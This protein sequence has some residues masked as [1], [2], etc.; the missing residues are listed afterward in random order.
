MRVDEVARDIKTRTCRW[1]GGSNL[2]SASTTMKMT[3]SKG[4]GPRLPPS[5][6]EA[7][8]GMNVL[9]GKNPVAKTRIATGTRKFATISSVVDSLCHI[10]AA[11]L[12]SRR[13]VYQD[14]HSIAN[15]TMPNC[16][17]FDVLNEALRTSGDENLCLATI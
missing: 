16:G 4:A 7:F 1:K 13:L 14:A 17:F 10:A 9:W 8:P 15:G 2:L 3:L 12:R 5:S 6:N 11:W